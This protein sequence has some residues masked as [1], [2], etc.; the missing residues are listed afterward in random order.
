MIPRYEV[1]A[2]SKI[3]SEDSRFKKMLEV[4]LA[5]LQAFEDEGSIPK[6]TAAAFSKVKI[7]PERIHEIEALTRH[8]VIAFC[9]SITEQVEPTFAR[10]FHFGVTSSDILD[11]ALS[12]QLR[13][14]L[15]IIVQDLNGLLAALDTQIEKT[16]NLLCLGRSHGMAAEPMVFAQKFLSFK[17]ELARR[18]VDY[19][20]TLAEELTGQFSGAV[21]NYSVITPKVELITLKKLNLPV[22][23]VSTQVL[24][25]DRIAKIISIGAL[26][27]SALE[28]LAVELRHLHHSDI[29]EVHEGFKPGQKGSSTMPHKKNPI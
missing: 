7:N 1:P 22:E 2:V 23:T 12:L 13:D 25:R 3:W 5:L 10:H 17:A 20:R 14:S 24:P 21:G 19:K 6:G 27:A 16:K 28:R 8:D 4:E 29:S 15:L 9:S 18:L 26:T 11:T